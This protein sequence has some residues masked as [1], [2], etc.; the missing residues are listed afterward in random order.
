[1]RTGAGAPAASHCRASGDG[2]S[3]SFTGTEGSRRK[4]RSRSWAVLISGASSLG[5]AGA[6][7]RAAQ[8]PAIGEGQGR[9]GEGKDRAGEPFRRRAAG[10]EIAV[11]LAAEA[12]AAVEREADPLDEPVRVQGRRQ[13]TG[14]DG[15]VGAA[16]AADPEG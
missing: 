9:A 11:A 1:M 14:E 7:H 15:P 16:A 4:F 8:N 2:R 12:V 5:T 10:G 13:V 6:G 3:D